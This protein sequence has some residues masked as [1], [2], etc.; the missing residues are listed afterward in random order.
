[1]GATEHCGLET[2]P[3]SPD[4]SMART[5]FSANSHSEDSRTGKD[6]G[7]LTPGSPVNQR[8][9]DMFSKVTLPEEQTY[10]S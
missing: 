10:C 2:L 8:S 1:M 6:L 3:L 7:E 9:Y 4:V 5:S